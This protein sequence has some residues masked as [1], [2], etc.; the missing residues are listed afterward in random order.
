MFDRRQFLV[1]GGAGAMFAA[2]AFPNKPNTRAR[3]DPRCICVHQ[4]FIFVLHRCGA[5]GL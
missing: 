4:R 5:D 3:T 1:A 2:S